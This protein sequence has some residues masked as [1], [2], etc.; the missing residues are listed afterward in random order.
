MYGKILIKT[1]LTVKTG[2]HIG[3]SN[4]F[5]AIGAVDSPVIRDPYTGL[6]IVPGSSLKGK[7]RS[8]LARSFSKDIENMPKFDDDN[9]IIK[10]VFGAAQP[11]PYR[12]RLQFSDSFVSNREEMN[13]V[14][15]TE[16]KTENGIDR[17]TSV[18]NPRQIERVT[19]GTKFTVNL[20]YDIDKDDE[21]TEDM[22]LIAKGLKLLQ[23]DYLGGHGTRGSGRV[24]FSGFDVE[25]YEISGGE[26]DFEEIKSMFD[27]VEEYEL[28]SV[29]A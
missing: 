27:E 22:Q 15:I 5:S 21:I 12:A 9:E 13:I 19:A 8:L 28:F 29:H 14:G 3:G 1:T 16:V 2:M 23:L 6:P 10:R 26:I 18:A 4:G 20:V 24:S 17:K 25:G 7:M 11:K